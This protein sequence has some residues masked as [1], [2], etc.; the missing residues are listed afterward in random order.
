MEAT[1]VQ[2]WAEE[3]AK[4]APVG[5]LL[6]ALVAATIALRS[7]R[8]QKDIA[9]KRAALD[10]LMK[11]ATENSLIELRKKA[12]TALD[13]YHNKDS[14]EVFEKTDDNDVL[15]AF[16]ELLELLAVGINTKVIDE[17]VCF[18]CLSDM[19]VGAVEATKGFL[20]E[21]PAYVCSELK[22]VNARWSRWIE[23]SSGQPKS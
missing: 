4:L 13:A 23:R 7:L 10:L 14:M 21:Q 2:W 9:R 6:T 19:L 18:D 12:V 11:L 15:R 8:A 16:L 3:I 17:V 5:T 22:S 20:A 1:D